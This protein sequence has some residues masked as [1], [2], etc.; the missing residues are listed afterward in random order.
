LLDSLLQ[1]LQKLQSVNG[2]RTQS[3]VHGD[4]GGLAVNHVGLRQILE[5]CKDLVS[6]MVLSAQI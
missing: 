3:Q 4:P 5:R 6:A 2:R 1:E